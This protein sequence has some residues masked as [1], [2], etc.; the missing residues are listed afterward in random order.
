V[1]GAGYLQNIINGWNNYYREAMFNNLLTARGYVI[2]DIDYRG[3]AGYG[4]EWRTDVYDFLGGLDLQDHLDGIDYAVANYSVDPKRVGM[5]GG[6]YG[7][8]MAEMAAMRAPE[9]INCAAALRPVADW[10]NYYA[11]SPIYTTERLGFPDKNVEA[12]RRSSPISYADKLSR[13]LLILHGMVDD[14]V[15]FQDSVQLVQKLIDLG[16]TDYFDVMFYPKE[17][18]GFTRP[19][20]WTDEYERILRFFDAHLK[21]SQP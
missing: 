12:Y 2:L 1:H 19:E 9:R 21:N 11:S 14:N 3:S 17:N 13:P 5:Y 4:R 18:H 15:H 20:S 7:G 8:F 10:K 6:S 16:K